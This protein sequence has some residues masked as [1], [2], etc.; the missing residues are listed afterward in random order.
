MAV[1]TGVGGGRGEDAVGGQAVGDRTE[2]AAAEELTEDAANY[3][4]RGRLGFELPGAL[5]GGGFGR[6]GVRSGVGELVA[7]RWPAAEEPALDCRLGGHGRS[8]PGLDPVASAFAHPAVEAHDDLVGVG[9]GVDGAA[10][11][12]G[13]TAPRCSGR[14]QGR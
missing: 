6:V 13:P 12:L 3:W 8:N 10:H 9:A 7:M 1:A 5:P 11:F 4:S 14:T 2:T